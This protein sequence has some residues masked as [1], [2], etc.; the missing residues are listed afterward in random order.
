MREIYKI[1]YISDVTTP[2]DDMPACLEPEIDKALLTL[3]IEGVIPSLP[4]TSSCSF[5]VTLR[6][7]NRMQLCCSDMA[8]PCYTQ[9]SFHETVVATNE[10]PCVI[11][12][13]ALNGVTGTLQ[14]SYSACTQTDYRI[15]SNCT[16]QTG[17]FVFLCT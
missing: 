17:E 10:S 2:N 11:Y 14:L 12:S 15:G 13:P 16:I 8:L 7:S 3:T 5:S 4:R 6:T 1:K 9:I